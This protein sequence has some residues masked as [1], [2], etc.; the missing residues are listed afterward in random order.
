MISRLK[1]VDILE[2][3]GIIALDLKAVLLEN[4]V[5]TVNIYRNFTDLF[6]KISK[7]R[8]GLIILDSADSTL[9]EKIQ[10]ITEVLQIPVVL[11]SGLPD[12]SLLKFKKCALL[13]KPYEKKDLC[14]L[15]TLT[16]VSD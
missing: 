8:C 2:P 11:L 15:L 3:E 16:S 4:G 5:E 7:E 12:E 14:N 9:P 10:I 13:K 6:K 1:S